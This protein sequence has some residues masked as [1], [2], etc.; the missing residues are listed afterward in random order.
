MSKNELEKIVEY[1]VAQGLA[2]IANNTEEQQATLDYVAIFSKDENE[3]NE[4]MQVAETLGEEVDKETI[5]TGRTFLLDDVFVTPAGNLLLLKIRKPDP[6]R[7]QRG[8]PDF[9]VPDYQSFKEKYIKKSGNFTLMLKTG[10]EMIEIKGVDVLV[11]IPSKPLG[12]RL[13]SR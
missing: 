1:I 11:Y 3:F 2:A 8:A 10:Y 12:D 13:K 9:K 4:L 5:K 6:T 7:L